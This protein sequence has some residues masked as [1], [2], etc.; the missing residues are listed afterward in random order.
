[1]STKAERAERV[2]RRVLP[3][4]INGQVVDADVR[5][6]KRAAKRAGTRWDAENQPE[7]V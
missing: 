1:M 6:D 3:V 2:K 5:R 4:R 7:A